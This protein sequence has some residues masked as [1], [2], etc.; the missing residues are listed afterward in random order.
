MHDAFDVA[1]YVRGVD[2]G[3]K[4]ITLALVHHEDYI[5]ENLTLNLELTQNTILVKF[6]SVS[7]VKHCVCRLH[8]T[9]TCRVILP[10][11]FRRVSMAGL[12][13]RCLLA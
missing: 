6:G 1:S 10:R 7:T 11:M 13:A 12:S 8:N 2:A 3:Y 9:H 5:E 4:A